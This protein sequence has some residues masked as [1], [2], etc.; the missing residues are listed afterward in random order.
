MR[1]MLWLLLISG[2]GGW[3]ARAVAVDE[4]PLGPGSHPETGILQVLHRSQQT[5]LDR[6]PSAERGTPAAEVLEISVQR[7]IRAMGL[8][9][10]VE[11]RIIS[12]DTV[13]ETVHGNV[14]VANDALAALPEGERMFILA[15]ELAH[16][17]LRHWSQ[18]GDLYQQYIPGSVT[19]EKTDAVAD[20]L[21]RDASRMARRHEFDA[22]AFA[23]RTLRELG[24]ADA[25]ALSALS[26]FGFQRDSA[27]HPGTR[28]RLAALCAIDE[29]A[30]IETAAIEASR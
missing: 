27:T 1:W 5:R 21:G 26:R 30:E 9:Q 11:L 23:L 7:L 19:P 12:G 2:L 16:V 29:P 22:D 15:H 4:G 14:I 20:A 13:A 10:P 25:H 28:K 24:Y 6:L 17:V 8:Q 18:V 3:S